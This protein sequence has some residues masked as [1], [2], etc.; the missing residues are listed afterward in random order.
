MPVVEVSCPHC[1][2][3]LKAPDTTAGKKG[4]CKKCGT[5]F[6]IPG[7]APNANESTATGGTPA[8]GDFALPT[9]PADADDVP[10]ATAVEDTVLVPPVP[11]SPPTPAAVDDEKTEIMAPPAPP[12]AKPVPPPVAKPVPPPVAA[13]AE[14]EVFSLDDAEPLEELPLATPPPA[15]KPASKDA[16]G[17]SLSAVP[18]KST[19]AN[20]PAPPSSKGDRAKTAKAESK[21][22]KKKQDEPVRA[23]APAAVAPAAATADNPFAFANAPSAPAKP[24]ESR[25]R[26][27]EDEEDEPQPKKK[28]REGSK[29]AAAPAAAP[30]ADNPFAFGL[31][32]EPA[33]PEKS[34]KARRRSD[35]EDDQDD[36]EQ[37]RR[38]ARPKEKGMGK[39]LLITGVVA[40]V[41]LALSIAAVVVY[42]IKNRAPE[43]TKQEKKEDPPAPAPSPD[44]DPKPPDPKPKSKENDP[45]QKPKE[46]DPP[47]AKIPR[48]VVGNLREFTVGALPA[49]L[50]PVDKPKTTLQIDSP[51]ATVKRVFPPFDARTG[52]THIL[53][54]TN[55]GVGG[56][57]EKLSLDTYSASTRNRSER[58][59]YD[60]D[61]QANPLCDLHASPTGVRFL[62]AVDGKIHVWNVVEPKKLV[63]GV[64]PYA[65]TPEHQK[66]G[67]A[68]AFLTSEPN[69]IITVSTAGAVHL[70]DTTTQKPVEEFIPPGGSPGKVVLGRTVALSQGGGSVVMFVGGVIYQIRTSSGLER[71]REFKLGGEP[72]RSYGLAASDTSGLIIYAFEAD[73]GKKTDKTEK[74]VLCLPMDAKREIMYRWPAALGDPVGAFW[75]GGSMGGVTSAR[76]TVWFFTDQDF[77]FLPL[78]LTQ[79]ASEPSLHLGDKLAYWYVVPREAKTQQAVLVSLSVPFDNFIEFGESYRNKQPLRALRISNAG[80]AK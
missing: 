54:Q 12:V 49:K 64:D 46:N 31:T 45:K 35:D 63:D 43:Q 42:V 44:P 1:Q 58:L 80:L 22:K 51:I 2:A 16:G 4:K 19:K 30:A 23:P 6:R 56:K 14:P 29:P 76:G 24:T 27:E 50:T 39:A 10:M 17:V 68:A 71:V 79:S 66:A 40:F 55:A 15:A 52:D 3:K 61:G 70:F 69:Q 78:A 47:V 28:R 25:R 41:A 36:E 67:L 48:L 72:A 33:A 9:T 18:E 5:T 57:G 32:N 65:T 74:V 60:G 73:V 11:P 62:A 34:A 77:T 13:K 37:K 8:L 59:E 7:G 21:P 20:K 75:A 53:V 38:Y 26:D